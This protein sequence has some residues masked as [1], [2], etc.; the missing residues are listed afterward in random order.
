MIKKREFVERTG[1]IDS[2][3]RSP[4][5]KHLGWYRF[6]YYLS[7]SFIISVVSVLQGLGLDRLVV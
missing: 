4:T 2:E 3:A 6:F 5:I 1:V 7:L